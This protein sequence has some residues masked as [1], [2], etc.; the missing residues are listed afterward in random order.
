MVSACIASEGS[1]ESGRTVILAF[2][3]QAYLPNI[4]ACFNGMAADVPCQCK[5]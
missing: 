5:A 2:H 3:R 1:S 4:D